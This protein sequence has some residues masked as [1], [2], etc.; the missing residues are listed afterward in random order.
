MM[1]KEVGCKKWVCLNVLCLNLLTTGLG[2][3]TAHGHKDRGTRA[4]G[5][6]AKKRGEGG[7]LLMFF[8]I[9]LV[10]QGG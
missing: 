5:G 8:V 6:R 10:S 2:L 1:D 7:R 9:W 3:V 4:G